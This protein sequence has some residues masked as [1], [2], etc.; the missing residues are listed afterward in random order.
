MKD[1]RRI[2][3]YLLTMSLVLGLT[4]T[5]IWF[6]MK[7]EANERLQETDRIS[8]WSRS[9]PEVVRKYREVYPSSHLPHI[10]TLIFGLFISLVAAMAIIS[11]TTR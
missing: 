3:D 2:M 8:E 9:F 7:S 10:A 4:A 11:V 1:V 5:G 6:F